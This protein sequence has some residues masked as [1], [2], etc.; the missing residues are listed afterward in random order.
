MSGTL[1]VGR[2]ITE[3]RFDL[4]DENGNTLR[5]IDD[6]IAID[7]NKMLLLIEV[8]IHDSIHNFN[9]LYEELMTLNSEI[10]IL[11]GVDWEVL[12]DFT[13]LVEKEYI[14]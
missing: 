3:I 5:R 7:Y 13:L 12:A 8:Y 11:E 14:D 10:R 2:N 6:E 1:D 4:I 9:E